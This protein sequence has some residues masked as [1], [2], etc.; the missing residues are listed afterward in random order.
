[1]ASRT[2]GILLGCGFLAVGGAFVLIMFFVLGSV[3]GRDFGFASLSRNKIGLVEIEGPI[4]GSR[5]WVE[6]IEA[7]RRDPS[8]K[9]VVIRVD[10]PGGDVASSQELYQAVRRLRAEKPVVASLGS[11]AASGGY[12]AVVAAD[13]I[14]ANPGTLTGS[15]G[16]VFE[17]PTLTDLLQKIGVRYH[18][19]KSGRLKDMG[20]FAR[21]P[22]E[23][24]EEILDSIIA[25]VYD[26][27]VQAV[28][29]GRG[30][31][32]EEILPL[33]DGRVF[34]GRQAMEVGLVDRM[35][36]LHEAVATAA[37]AADLG[38][39]PQVVRKAR[40]RGTLYYFLDRLLRE[41]SLVR[42]SPTLSYRFQ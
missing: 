39:V 31:T 38:G 17:F 11:V 7:N 40:P 32:R 25:D 13:S 20:S 30:M 4:A 23:E 5:H 10:S 41:T 15:I 6:E 42:S 16:A 28:S 22:S 3:V 27:F 8:I 33:A 24:D 29:D 18:V 2:Q 21:P 14:L 26:Q 1:M 34:S 36:D 19:Y 12:Y 9:A 37:R 35:G